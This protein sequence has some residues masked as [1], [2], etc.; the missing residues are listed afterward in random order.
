LHRAARTIAFLALALGACAA[1]QAPPDTAAAAEAAGLV[2]KHFWETVSVPLGEPCRKPVSP[3][4]SAAGQGFTVAGVTTGIGGEV[5]VRVRLDDGSL[6]YLPYFVGTRRIAWTSQDPAA[7]QRARDAQLEAIN[8]EIAEMERQYCTGGTLE[9]GMTERAAVRAWCFPDR[10]TSIET[11]KGTR[12]EWVY[13]H[14][15]TLYFKDGRLTE[16]RRLD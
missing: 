12:E 11:A 10:A 7:A 5:F 9:I 16:I 14:R 4:C 15:G 3:L 1:P 6:G 8:E 13:P 2:G